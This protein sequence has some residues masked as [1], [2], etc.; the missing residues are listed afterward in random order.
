MTQTAVDE[1]WLR[2]PRLLVPGMQP[3]GLVK[4]S[5][6]AFRTNT[7]MLHVARIGGPSSNRNLM[8]GVIGCTEIS[9]SRVTNS[10][11]LAFNDILSNGYFPAWWLNGAELV[12]IGPF[13]VMWHGVIIDN[14]NGYPIINNSGG[15]YQWGL[16][17][18]WQ[19][20]GNQT[21][22]QTA[23]SACLLIYANPESFSG[24]SIANAFTYGKPTCF[25]GVR[26]VSGTL[27]LFVD[28]KYSASASIGERNVSGATQHQIGI[29]GWEVGI[30]RTSIGAWGN[31]TY[32][33]NTNTMAAA[34]WASALSDAEAMDIS[35]NPYS[36][37]EPA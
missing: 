7:K 6:L 23:N 2:E 17:A 13:A 27:K 16:R 30:K 15:S 34:F 9:S 18:N 4:P 33:S 1:V 8:D 26:P 3:L 29:S 14:T 22:N 24:V 21:G 19:A 12:G 31:T 28:G 35:G 11:G 20:N 25:V 32:H 10:N 37:V 5:R 36:L